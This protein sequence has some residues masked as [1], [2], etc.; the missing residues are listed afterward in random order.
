VTDSDCEQY[1]S[2]SCDDNLSHLPQANEV[3]VLYIKYPDE[4]CPKSCT[5]CS[6]WNVLDQ[7]II[8]RLWFKW[9][10]ANYFVVEHKYFETF[11]IIM[12]LA[13]SGALVSITLFRMNNNIVLE[14]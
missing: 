10:V 11:I 14:I 2:S 12:I 1:C 4:C 13:S 3:N 6:F 8:G 5:S 7:T 9:R